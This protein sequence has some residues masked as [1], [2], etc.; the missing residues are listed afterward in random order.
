ML[1]SRTCWSL[2][3]LSLVAACGS[4][5]QHEQGGEDAGSVPSAAA[6]V[7]LDGVDTSSLT[8]REHATWSSYVNELL[9]PCPEVAVSVAQCVREKR[10]CAQ[11]LPAAKFL[12]RQVQAGNPKEVV[13]DVFAARFDPKR[14]KT[15]AI[16]DS[17]AKGA[18]A[19]VVTLVEFADFECGGCGMA[20]PLLEKIYKKHG[21]K[22]K[23]VFKHFPLE[24]HH[25]NAKLAAQAAYAAQVQGQ[26]WKMHNALFENQDRLTEPDLVAYAQ[27]IGLDVE[28]FK[29]DLH[30]DE[31]KARV[32][33][34]KKQGDTL[35]VDG[36]P[37]IFINGRQ[38]DLS[39]LPGI[40]DLEEWVTLE[41]K[42]AD[43]HPGTS[44]SAKPGR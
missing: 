17:P 1:M 32:E 31:A 30:S 34:E 40:D 27:E 14:V 3:L 6:K 19:P 15:I 8:E 7:E 35:G 20:Y 33:Q 26:F 23:L 21:K 29:K 44:S 39:K 4:T 28:R 22:M 11:C 9:A 2:L 25:P 38:C 36:T 41:I 16:G 12:L 5:C 18:E 42:L 13:A 43:T 10:D 24:E 37:T